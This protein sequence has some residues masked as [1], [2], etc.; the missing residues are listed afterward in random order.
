M[1]TKEEYIVMLKKF[2]EKHAS[3]YGIRSIGI[4]GSVAR[5]ENRL[6][7]D[8]DVFV[9]LEEADPFVMF[10]IREALQSLFGCKV[11]L[12]RLRQGLRSSLL[13]RIEK[14]GIPV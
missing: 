7:S 11:D 9:D 10:D 2:K 14:E 4:F 8:V 12:V 6:D 5:G 1:K 13:K 3:R